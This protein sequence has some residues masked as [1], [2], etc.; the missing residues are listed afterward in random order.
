MTLNA[1]TLPVPKREMTRTE[2]RLETIVPAL[3][4]IEISPTALTGI[5]NSGLIS[6]QAVP[7]RESGRP[8]LIKVV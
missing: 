4:V 2:K 5:P 7:R 1:V 3:T 8:K 6:G